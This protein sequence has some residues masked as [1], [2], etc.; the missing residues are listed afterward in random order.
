MG[1]ACSYRSSP[2]FVHG[3]NFR[4]ERNIALPMHS[5]KSLPL[6]SLSQ[7]DNKHKKKKQQ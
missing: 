1:V 3:Q 6:F 4:L 7:V 2:A 5:C